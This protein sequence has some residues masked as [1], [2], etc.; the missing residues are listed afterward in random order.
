MIITKGLTDKLSELND[1]AVMICGKKLV[2]KKNNRQ[3]RINEV[4]TGLTLIS[5][6]V[7]NYWDAE[8]L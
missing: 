7:I 2:N 6:S 4:V 8:S 5:K 3:T 1:K